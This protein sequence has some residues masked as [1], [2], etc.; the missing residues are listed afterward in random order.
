MT[1]T[2]KL[3]VELMQEII[4]VFHTTIDALKPVPGLIYSISFQPLSKTLLSESAARGGNSL[5]LSPADG[6][7]II[8][9]LYSFWTNSTDDQMVISTQQKFL[10]Q[11][12]ELA[13]AKGNASAF[14]FM[15][16]SYEGQDPINGYGPRSKAMLQATSKKYDP[17]G[18]FQNGAPGGF[19]LF[20]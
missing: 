2:I 18:F 19:K 16:Y 5:G 20:S 3:D 11:V 10:K 4:D 1:T 13:A 8:L 17:D 9:L 15:A 7:L 12:D 6:H 14:K